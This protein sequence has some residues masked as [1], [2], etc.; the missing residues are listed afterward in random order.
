MLM[1]LMMIYFLTATAGFSQHAHTSMEP[2]ESGQSA[3]AAIAEIVEIL[4]NDPETDWEAVKISALQQHLS[5][6]DSLVTEAISTQ[7]VGADSVSFEV[8]GPPRVTEALHRMVPAHAPFLEATTGW[9]TS[10]TKTDEGVI[11]V[12]KG[13]LT[14]IEAL[15]FFGLMTIGAHHQT[16]HLGIATGKMVHN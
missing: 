9:E 6:M 12:V 2:Q 13:D 8:V 14:K 7:L 10:A 16:H 5:D 1:R 4:R 15:G 3:F 11:L